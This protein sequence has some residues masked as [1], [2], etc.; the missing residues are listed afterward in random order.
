ML[1]VPDGIFVTKHI[2]NLEAVDL[3][4]E[5]IHLYRIYSEEDVVR[6]VC[7][8]LGYHYV[9][10]KNNE[11]GFKETSLNNKT[12]VVSLKDAVNKIPTAYGTN[13]GVKTYR[14]YY[15]CY[16]D[17]TDNTSLRFVVII[18]PGDE[19]KSNRM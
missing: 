4:K 9:S 19:K 10:S 6:N 14:T 5:D 2:Q 1:K 12:S 17:I 11:A 8:L 18:R 7:K 13:N 15:P 3:P 16:A